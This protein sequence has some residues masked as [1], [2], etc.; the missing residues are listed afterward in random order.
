[1]TSQITITALINGHNWCGYFPMIK[2]R[3]RSVVK[4]ADFGFIER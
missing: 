3:Q 1:M 4:E 2:K